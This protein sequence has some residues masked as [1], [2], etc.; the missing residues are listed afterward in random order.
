MFVTLLWT[1]F[2][3]VY[4]IAVLVCYA[5]IYFTPRGM[6]SMVRS[7]S[8]SL[9]AH[10]TRKP[11]GWTSPHSFS[12]LLI[13]VARSSSGGVEICYVLLVL[14]M[15]LCFH[16]MALWRVMYIPK[17]QQNTRTTRRLTRHC[18]VNSEYLHPEG[19][20]EWAAITYFVVD[21]NTPF[22]H[23]LVEECL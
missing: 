14:W 20:C 1:K 10:I 19:G 8:V 9:S 23:C 15:R 21:Q 7:M 13:G 6:K 11:H 16:I 4:Q 2:C 12:M 3:Y 17:L 18:F 22:F 5:C